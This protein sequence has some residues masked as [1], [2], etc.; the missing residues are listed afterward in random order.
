[1]VISVCGLAAPPPPCHWNVLG[2]PYALAAGRSA[3]ACV[4]VYVC[5][6]ACM[7]H[8]IPVD[9]SC[10]SQTLPKRRSQSSSSM[11]SLSLSLSLPSLSLSPFLHPFFSPSLS[12]SAYLSINLYGSRS[13][14]ASTLPALAICSPAASF[15]LIEN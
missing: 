11:E 3:C 15:C 9:L 7:R 10:L 12:T 8:V 2:T 5:V 13:L 14:Y 1:M 6:R 4:R